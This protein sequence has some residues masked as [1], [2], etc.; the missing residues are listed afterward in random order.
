VSIIKSIGTGIDRASGILSPAAELKR[1]AARASIE[2][3]RQYAA[4]KVSRTTGDWLPCNQDVNSIIR[5]S[6]PI[7]KSRIRQLVRDFPYFDRATNILVDYTVGTGMSFQSRVLNT[8]WK[9]GSAEKKL[10]RVTC[11]KIEDAVAW[12]MEQADASG[13]LHFSEMERLAGRQDVESGEYLFVKTILKDKNRY[14][15]YSWMAYEADWLTSSYADVASGNEVDQ[16]IE[17]NPITGQVVAYHFAVPSGYGYNLL[18]STKPVRVLAENV[19]HD[20]ETRRPG[21]RRG[22][23]PFVTAVLIAHDLGDYLD[24]TIDTAKLAAKY[25]EIVETPDVAGFQN[26]RSTPGQG[27]NQGKKIEHLENAIIE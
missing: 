16:G 25:L 6:S 21:Q 12:A 27:A 3:A 24:A 8:N 7:L 1:I 26:L 13:K 5:T 2:G 19:I 10:D 17:F 11:Q 22:V 18:A 4:A 9:P 15:P 23:S 14:I 20:F